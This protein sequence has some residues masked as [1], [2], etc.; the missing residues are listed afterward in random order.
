V[1]RRVE[2]EEEEEGRGRGGARQVAMVVAK[3][4]TH[5]YYA[6]HACCV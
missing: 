3:V 4:S 6:C 2:K 1:R 5:H